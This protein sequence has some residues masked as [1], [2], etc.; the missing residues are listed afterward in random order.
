MAN[1]VLNEETMDDKMDIGGSQ[2]SQD[3]DQE[4]DVY[5]LCW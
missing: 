2:D 4:T 5:V 3:N 1:Q